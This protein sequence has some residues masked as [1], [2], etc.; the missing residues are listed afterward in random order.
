[1]AIDAPITSRELKDKIENKFRQQIPECALFY[2]GRRIEDNETLIPLEPSAII[3]IV[4]LSRTTLSELNLIFRVRKNL[5][6]PNHPDNIS[7]NAKV[8]SDAYIRDVIENQI[9][10][11]TGKGELDVFLVYLGRPLNIFKK[12]HEELV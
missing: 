7:V 6:E 11:A 10:N 12:F 1:M 8:R 9:K 4:D 5:Q 3:H 2:K